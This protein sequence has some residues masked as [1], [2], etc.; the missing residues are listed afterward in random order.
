MTRA[1]RAPADA[2]RQLHLA[3]VFF[4]LA[5]PLAFPDVAVAGVG[6]DARGGVPS[7]GIA[8]QRSSVGEALG[9]LLGRSGG[10]PLREVVAGTA[11]SNRGDQTDGREVDLLLSEL[12]SA[13]QHSD[14]AAAAALIDFPLV[15]LKAASNGWERNGSW[16]SEEWLEAV[17]PQFNGPPAAKVRR[18]HAISMVTDS[19]AWVEDAR[20]VIAD[21]HLPDRVQR[22]ALVIRKGRRWLVKALVERT[23]PEL[24]S[25]WTPL[26][27]GKEPGHGAPRL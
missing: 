21:T 3:A 10:L 20:I 16:S 7:D 14:L 24:V 17:E 13:Y 15:V 9:A 27:E 25:R 1:I 4:V 2:L 5:S 22:L 26:G 12:D 18:G 19:L 23:W 11:G 8:S 6:D